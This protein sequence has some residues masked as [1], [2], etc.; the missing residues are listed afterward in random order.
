MYLLVAFLL[1]ILIPI[2]CFQK[3]NSK[4]LEETPNYELQ[5]L[6][7]GD[8][9][10]IDFAV[11]ADWSEGN[12]LRGYNAS[13]IITN[14]RA[15]AID[16][17]TLAYDL[18]GSAT[19]TSMWNGNYVQNE[20]T[21]TASD[22]GWNSTIPANGGSVNFGF[23]GTYEG[24]ELLAT[25]FSLNGEAIGDQEPLPPPPSPNPFVEITLVKTEEWQTGP[26]EYGFNA[27]VILA[28]HSNQIIDPWALE[29]DFKANITS[30]WNATYQ[31]DPEDVFHYT[32]SHAGWNSR[33]EPNSSLTFGFQGNYTDTFPE[34]LN[35]LLNNEPIGEAA[36]P[37]LPEPWQRA[38]LNSGRV[39]SEYK[40]ETDTFTLQVQPTDV[41]N[42]ATHYVYQEMNGNFTIQG[43]IQNLTSDDLE[44][45]AGIML[46]KDNTNTSEYVYVYLTGDRTEVEY[47]EY[48]DGV[49]EVKTVPGQQE[50]TSMC[51]KLEREEN[52]VR[53][54]ERDA[55]LNWVLITTIA[56]SLV[57][58]V[59]IGL[60]V[61]ASE[62]VQAVV[63]DVVVEAQGQPNEELKASFTVSPKSGKVPLVVDFD[64]SDSIGSNLTYVWDFGEGTT[65]EGQQVSHTYNTPERYNVTLTVSDANSSD[66]T[67]TLVVVFSEDAFTQLEGDP[68]DLAGPLIPL[69]YDLELQPEDYQNYHDSG[70]FV[71]VN[72]LTIEFTPDV[73]VGE[74]NEI[75]SDI[76][77]EII[78]GLPS[79]SI[80]GAL[81]VRVAT[82]THGEIEVVIDT[83]R[84]HPKV[85]L[86]F[87]DSLMQL[88]ALPQPSTGQFLENEA[89]TWEVEPS[90]GNWGLEFIR[91]P[92]TWNL[93]ALVENKGTSTSIVIVDAEATESHPDLTYQYDFSG[94]SNDGYHGVAIAGIIG[95]KFSNQ[96]GIDGVNPFV[97]MILKNEDT[98]LFLDPQK[99][100]SFN[101]I[102]SNILTYFL[103]QQNNK[104]FNISIGYLPVDFTIENPGPNHP[105][106]KIQELAEQGGLSFNKLI[107]LRL[108]EITGKDPPPLIV[109]SAGNGSD[110]F[111]DDISN[112]P[113][114]QPARWN[115][116]YT[117]AA[118]QLN[119]PNIIV[120][121]A[122]KLSQSKEGERS[123]FSN[124][125]SV[126]DGDNPQRALSAPGECILTTV[127]SLI[128]NNNSCANFGSQYYE[129]LDG[130]SFSTP[131]IVGLISYL[132][133]IDETL[134]NADIRE[135][136]FD[137]SVEVLGGASNSIDAFASAMAI[138]SLDS[139]P[140]NRV[141]K[142]FLDIDDN[143]IDGN[144]RVLIGHSD[145]PPIT[146]W[147]A[148]PTDDADNNGIYDALENNKLL[149]L[150]T[151]SD[152]G[153]ICKDPEG[154]FLEA[155]GEPQANEYGPVGDDRID[156]SDFRR[157][158][159]AL[160][161]AEGQTTN[162]N[163]SNENSKKDLNLDGVVNI[164]GT[165]N[166]PEE[167]V[168][169]RA[170]FNGDGI[171]SRDETILFPCQNTND[172]RC[173]EKTDLQVFV[174]AAKGEL[175][176]EAIWDD[177]HYTPDDIEQLNLLDSGDIEV[178]PH[179]FLRTPRYNVTKVI[180]I[181]KSAD[182]SIFEERTHTL[183]SN[184]PF[185]SERHIY[186]LPINNNPYSVEVEAYSG[187][188]LM[189]SKKAHFTVELGG[190]ILYDPA[191]V[192]ADMDD[193]SVDGNQR[194]MIGTQTS[195]V[196]S[197][198]ID[199]IADDLPE[200]DLIIFTTTQFLNED[201][202]EDNYLGDGDTGIPA[203]G[204]AIEGAAFTQHVDMADFRRFRDWLLMATN[205]GELDG[206]SDN[207][208]KEQ[209]TNSIFKI[210][211]DLNGDGL[212]SLNDRVP[213]LDIERLVEFGEAFTVT[214]GFDLSGGIFAQRVEVE[215]DEVEDNLP[216]LNDFEVFYNTIK[217]DSL[218][219]D[220]DYEL[221]EIPD[222][223]DSGDIT[224]WPRACAALSRWTDDPIIIHFE[225][226]GT[227]EE[228]G[229][230]NPDGE[231]FVATLPKG[232]YK[233][234][235]IVNLNTPHG[236]KQIKIEREIS[237]GLGEDIFWDPFCVDVKFTANDRELLNENLFTG[238]TLTE[239]DL[240]EG[241]PVTVKTP[242]VGIAGDEG[243]NVPITIDVEG[244][245]F[246]SIEKSNF[247][248]VNNDGDVSGEL[249]NWQY[250]EVA[251]DLFKGTYQLNADF[252]STEGDNV[253][254]Q[255]E[256]DII[257]RKD[258]VGPADN[259]A[260]PHLRSYDNRH[261]GFP[262]HAIG[263]YVLTRSTIPGDDFEI[264][265]RYIAIDQLILP[266]EKRDRASTTDAAAMMIDGQ[267][268]EFYTAGP[269]GSVI[270]Y[271]NGEEV[272]SFPA[273]FSG[274]LIKKIYYEHS[275]SG[276]VTIMTPDGKFV[277]IRSFNSN[278]FGTFIGDLR[279]LL[280]DK[281]RGNLEGLHGNGNGLVVDDI[282][283]RG[284][285]T[286]SR[287]KEETLYFGENIEEYF[288]GPGGDTFRD[289]WS[290]FYGASQS[291]FSQG[292]DPFS[293]T[294]PRKLID[295]GDFDSQA[296]A[297]AK[298]AC[299]SAGI[300][301]PWILR[302]CT[303]DVALTGDL[304][305][306]TAALGVSAPSSKLIFS[307]PMQIFFSGDPINVEVDVVDVGSGT[308][309]S[310][311]DI[312][313]DLIGPNVSAA[314]L[315]INGH[316]AS[317]VAPGEK[318]EYQIT[319][320]LINDPLENI[321]ATVVVLDP[322]VITPSQSI[323]YIH[324][325]QTFVADVAN[326]FSV[327]WSV[328]PNANLQK[329]GES[330]T[331]N[332][333]DTP[334]QYTLT[335]Y[336]V[337]E[338]SRKVSIPINVLDT[339]L[340]PDGVSIIPNQNVTF[341][342]Q[343]AEGLE[344][345]WSATGGTIDQNG[346]YTAPATPGTYTI[347]ATVLEDPSFTASSIVYVGINFDP[348]A[349]DDDFSFTPDEGQTNGS[350]TTY[351]LDVLSNDSDPNNDPLTIISAT[352]PSIG[353]ISI[354]E[355]Q[356][357][358]YTRE[359]AI[360]GIDT[361]TYTIS[362]GNGGEDTAMVTVD[363]QD[364]GGW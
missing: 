107:N 35:V 293:R 4:P 251:K 364:G 235:V 98:P 10:V 94:E 220:P 17:W 56:L 208:K 24:S 236:I 272:S 7:V 59:Q 115:S 209:T 83:L 68:D 36:L 8:E 322:V 307:D 199:G 105:S 277:R 155:Y 46:R 37:D 123:S 348:E 13:I 214:E 246:E 345:E 20:N 318:A 120:A 149:E 158:R 160:L 95:A 141:L 313:W 80:G 295:L 304:V 43:C 11:T 200:E 2:A 63:D 257:N 347:T 144:Q 33:I 140:P 162:L 142:A 52:S 334:N 64:A 238:Y 53:V 250:K 190:D 287:P 333:S 338:P 71:S 1:L 309:I 3:K 331:F 74:V 186:T 113:K 316:N 22:A 181:V 290:L 328:T 280:P 270:I 112:P 132:F 215:R 67:S 361:F 273:E 40:E 99:N 154:N 350:Q 152:Y 85:E 320:S 324:D 282:Q 86:V 135:L 47:L 177:E 224:V 157:F 25:A 319:A 267:H 65:A 335:A 195:P 18:N 178:W 288:A 138:D 339:K 284:G 28:N 182:G 102:T 146:D 285:E 217:R 89:W 201:A 352:S 66:S 360:T 100:Q 133:S 41:G 260:D 49:A 234:T 60:A 346:A 298:E 169:P 264:Q 359:T 81:F 76:G 274:V 5:S 291:L 61:C 343:S 247:T 147:C 164:D 330:V 221:E 96:Q 30:M 323:M 202:D 210:W 237:L 106:L 198:D 161:Q 6:S 167:N 9:I 310:S 156:M 27:D 242:V 336:L 311:S 175:W 262:F 121:E 148:N 211:G 26:N 34:L 233:G 122:I 93:N 116:P 278:K 88:N 212:I 325:S 124:V 77:A 84:S 281:Y 243:V 223:L 239:N 286:L 203:T 166:A 50:S 72:I 87:E 172:A 179:L 185:E 127:S 92:Q 145:S 263:D 253:Q 326:G 357:I 294:Y 134:S 306:V 168:Y 354:F 302:S 117:Y 249:R 70:L 79:S 362:D 351:F 165:Q 261:I 69:D 232:S 344:V 327:D 356:S 187:E 305:W 222:L 341:S 340:E 118:L 73:T 151:D 228:K 225:N 342:W 153:Q 62:E 125:V 192:L 314:D 193:G 109:V 216:L 137:N 276:L 317:F 299:A 312:V 213:V 268:L 129:F 231:A 176:G 194:L 363:I 292:T 119:N 207:P 265:V 150:K 23:E 170:D 38:T 136:L 300:E 163:G 329:S 266:F 12:G 55:D 48:V 226:L 57:D 191:R 197:N 45:R 58:T 143:T 21:I 32:I 54:Y 229:Y 283:I 271:V 297:D 101:N 19:V 308:P 296:V 206:A 128:P 111:F 245:G 29:L 301:H 16:G 196:N 205:Q 256:F 108:F 315:N 189:F 218:W 244:S 227:G 252:T 188:T 51:Y 248:A 110:Q 44:A 131:H 255:S 358:D 349:N 303:F 275:E 78:G 337:E 130:T 269:L 183:D 259:F 355:G 97:D 103:G 14:N 31:I 126:E 353:T 184:P 104:V 39:F 42:K 90:G 159:D 91:V 204:S 258:S 332:A 279:I 114:L 173:S 241:N 82:Q 219:Q 174:E 230:E 171:I 321:S 15:E 75:L 254:S 139:T 180:S 240:S 289:S